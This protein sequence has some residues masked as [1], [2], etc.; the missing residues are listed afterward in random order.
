MS[1]IWR[2][3]WRDLWGNKFRTLLVVLST[4]V[5][6]FAIG[7][8]FGLSDVMRSRMIQTHRETIPAHVTF[9][10][11]DTFDEDVVETVA[12]QYCPDTRNVL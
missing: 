7:L 3:V 1:I 2:K 12:N 6:I 8:V 11:I 9:W 4:A 5:G 10:W